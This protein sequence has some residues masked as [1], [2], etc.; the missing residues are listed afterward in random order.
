MAALRHQQI[1]HGILRMVLD[2]SDHLGYSTDL[3][4]LATFFRPTFPDIGN[5]E[6]VDTLKRLR[7]K[8]LTLC[9]YPQGQQSCLEYPT[10]ISDDEEFFYRHG[11]QMRRTPET[12][13]RA[14]ELAALIEREEKS[15]AA[16]FTHL[17]RLG[18]DRVKHDLLNGGF[19]W[20]GGTMEQQEEAWEWVRM[21]EGEAKK[22]DVSL[23]ERVLVNIVNKADESW[24]NIAKRMLNQASAK[25]LHGRLHLAAKEQIDPIHD[26]AVNQMVESIS[27]FAVKNDLPLSGLFQQF[28]PQ[29]A[30]LNARALKPVEQVARAVLR[31]EALL[32]RQLN[33][34]T[35]SFEERCKRA[36]EQEEF[37][38][39]NRTGQEDGE[40]E[41]KPIS[42][43]RKVFI[44]HGHDE[45][46][47]EKVA[48]FLTQLELEPIILHE[49][50]SRNRTIIEKFEANSREVGFAVVLLTPD[51]EGC[52]RGGAHRPRARQN[53]V[54]ELGYFV[55]RLGRERVCALMR[56][57]V[58][59]P[60]D[61]H[62]VVYV[63]FDEANSWKQTLG[64]ELEAAGFTVDWNKV[65]G[66][67][68]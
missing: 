58:E 31:E 23:L 25:G 61:L 8:Y 44:V 65:M 26:A 22:P 11:F 7:P 18:L 64:G 37:E 35:T 1:E 67:R 59:V 3:P 9:K 24:K 42:I 19:R 46:A 53:V 14:Q 15:H 12:D 38:V 17:D 21:K 49:Q 6:L 56:G 27:K 10:E 45:A 2:R 47:K 16:R 36:Q 34:V 68:T 54:F 33:A 30:D 55:G 50:V 62:G 66:A 39:M 51:D 60:S 57:E 40:R 63:P 13:P 28:E 5:R 43:S 4:N 20:V 29:F 32:Q 48:R 41:G 52:E